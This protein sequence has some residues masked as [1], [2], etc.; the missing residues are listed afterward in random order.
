MESRKIVYKETLIVAIGLVPCVGIMLGLCALLNYF[1]QSVW[2]GG[3]VGYVL[4][5][6]NFFF[7]AVGTSLAADKAAQQDVHGGQKT[8][9]MSF[10]LRQVLL[11]VIIVICVKSG[12]CNALTTVLP[13]V[14]VRPI[15]TLSEFFRK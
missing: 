8:L 14:F 5:L 12:A 13:L 7:M 9:R 3:I 2:V 15:L 11:L 6:A 4:A 10:T 1:D